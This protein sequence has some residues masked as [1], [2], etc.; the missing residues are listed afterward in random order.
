[1]S[2]T[3]T[4]QSSSCHMLRILTWNANG[5][6][7][8]K[9]EL[10]HYMEEEKID[11]ALISETHLNSR[12]C[13]KFRG[14]QLYTSHHPNDASHGGSAI[15]IRN[16]LRHNELPNYTS[17]QLQ[18]TCI[19]IQFCGTVTTIAAVYNP[20]RHTLSEESYKEFFTYLGHRWIAGGDWNAKN[21]HW[22]SR[23]NSSKGVKLYNAVTS[24]NVTYI[25][26]G[27][28]TYW[29]TDLTKHPDCIDFFLAKGVAGG[30]CEVHS[31][32]DLSSDHTPV[33]L[34]LGGT[35]TTQQRNSSLTNK[36]TNWELYRETLHNQI[37]LLQKIRSPLGIEDAIE[38]FSLLIKE[39][40]VA[41]TPIINSNT[42]TKQPISSDL[43]AAIRHR[44]QLRHRWQ[45]TRDPGIKTEFNR[46]CLCTKQLLQK[47]SN[48]KFTS[49]L[50]SLDT[51]S[52]TNYSLYKAA[53]VARKTQRH[54]PPLKSLSGWARTDEEKV[55]V[56]ASHL[57]STFMPH[58]IDTPLTPDPNP[59][60]GNPIKYI[61]P[62]EVKRFID[63][64][65]PHKAPGFD[66]ITARLMRELPN[67]GIC[68]LAQIFNA[69]VRFRHFPQ[70]WK[71]AKV[72]LLP[73]PGKN[74][75]EVASYRPISLLP[76]M[77]KLFEK[78]LHKRISKIVN[79]HNIIPNHQFG[80]RGKHATVEQV[81]RV[82]NTIRTAMENK[83]HCPGIFLDVSQAFDRVWISGLLHKLSAYLPEQVLS[84]LSSYLTNRTFRVSLGDATSD[85]H[86]IQAGVPQGSVL[87]PLLYVL[88]TADLPTSPSTTTA[89]FADD[90][91]VLAP[92][93]DY[94]AAVSTL[95]SAVDN[96]STWACTWKIKIN[97]TKST[98]V[99][100][101][102]RSHQYTPTL[103]GE[104]PVP[105]TTSVKYLG[106]HLDSRLTWQKH[107]A[108][109][110][111]ALKIRFRELYWL[112]HARNHLSLYNKRLL[113]VTVLRP[114]WTYGIPIWGY[115]APSNIQR[116]QAQQNIILRKITGAP[117]YVTNDTLHRDLQLETVAEIA[118]RF[119]KRYEHRLHKHPNVLAIQLLEDPPIRRLCRRMPL[120]IA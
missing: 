98:R 100:F 31:V 62:L 52:D 115:A 71:T 27:Q 8:R 106:I 66:H 37:N 32:T 17:P 120:D 90:T 35:V 20:P 68:R 44:R 111:E 34:E 13:I 75:E 116:L 77:S 65:N 79:E 55:K 33:L 92:N 28:P 22:G 14:Y 78:I 10:L 67:K 56:F 114:L 84:L 103:I 63:K 91:A 87:G 40:A 48:N 109:K 119:T 3:N 4:Q 73:K 69:I 64:L 7:R 12:H 88:Y 16:N 99:D 29:P 25:S 107:I 102:L 80:F 38:A 82:I 49:F 96:I 45:T 108:S 72:I 1:M 5:L 23:I 86:P 81:S 15:L 46:A 74:P 93:A 57:A 6:L 76:V 50:L 105:L 59:T 118:T 85:P 53:K 117:Y 30:Y 101:S 42:P 2:C 47:S 60:A 112:L 9:I 36:H 110:R 51:T 11:I 58:D 24:S 21:K 97:N 26:S 43:R 94:Y 104:R 70:H 19:S 89:T 113:Y 95:Q 83:E 18:A 41:A 54:V 61:A 39:A